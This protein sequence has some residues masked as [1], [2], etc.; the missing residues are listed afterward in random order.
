L[1][2]KPVPSGAFF[3][4]ADT[5]PGVYLHHRSELGE[6]QLTSDS[7]IATFTRWVSMPPIIDQLTADQNEAFR[8]ICHTIG[9]SI[10]FP[11]NK[12]DGKQTINGARGLNRKIADRLDLTLECIRR[13]YR[14]QA[15]PLDA[16]LQRYNDFFSLFDDFHGYVDFFLLQDLVTEDF[17]QVK[18]FMHFDDF[19]TPSVPN[20]VD[21]YM[22][23]R[24]LSIEFVMA[25]NRRI[26]QVMR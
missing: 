2:S 1:W 3:G 24:R 25:R 20:D 10:V 21:T 14:S 26:E 4:L 15:S 12:I 7:V 23:Y 18:F 9:G 6:F 17:D 19:T 16:A 13:Y 8:A 22:E 11:G 5:T